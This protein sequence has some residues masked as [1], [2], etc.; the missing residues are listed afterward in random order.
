[1]PVREVAQ[2]VQGDDQKERLVVAAFQE[3]DGRVRGERI[4][5]HAMGGGSRRAGQGQ[6]LEAVGIAGVGEGL[7]EVPLSGIGGAIA[8]LSEDTAEGGQL[9]GERIAQDVD[10]DL[11]RHLAGH[12]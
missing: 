7:R 10:A 6:E 1:M 5:V 4:G 9:F 11:M 2:V 3:A 12:Q 8:G